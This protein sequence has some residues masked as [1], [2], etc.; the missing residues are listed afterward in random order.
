MIDSFLRNLQWLVDNKDMDIAREQGVIIQKTFRGKESEQAV[1]DILKSKQKV[2]RSTGGG[3]NSKFRVWDGKSIEKKRDRTSPNAAVE[4]KK[5]KAPKA[6]APKTDKIEDK[7]VD[8]RFLTLSKMTDNQMQ[9]AFETLP[10]LKAFAK[11]HG[12][13]IR[14]NMNLEQVATLI[15]EKLNAKDNSKEEE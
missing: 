6:K 5:V 4:T 7:I 10:K 14:N 1:A 13:E 9:K 11:G 3:G 2:A 15:R 12:V 8:E